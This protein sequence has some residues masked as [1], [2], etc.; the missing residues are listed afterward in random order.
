MA[1]EDTLLSHHCHGILT[2][3]AGDGAVETCEK[4]LDILMNQ[5]KLEFRQLAAQVLIGVSGDDYYSGLK[6][7]G[8]G[9][10]VWG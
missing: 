1:R 4:L 9:F 2:F 5:P 6:V 10:G 8:L 3:P 7:K